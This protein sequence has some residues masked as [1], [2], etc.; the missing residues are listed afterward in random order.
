VVWLGGRYRT[1]P[2]VVDNKALSDVPLL[3]DM[4]HNVKRPTLADLPAPFGVAAPPWQVKSVR[5]FCPFISNFAA[6]APK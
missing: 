4:V 3:A 2:L 1:A 5:K 6:A